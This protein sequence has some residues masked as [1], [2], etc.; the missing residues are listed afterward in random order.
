MTDVDPRV[1]QAQT[2]FWEIEALRRDGRM[3]EASPR[4][5]A[6]ALLHEQRAIE[7]LEARDA[8]GWVDLF[9]AV[10]AFADAG[11]V[12]R[13]ARLLLHGRELLERFKAGRSAVLS[14]LQATEEWLRAKQN[15]PRRKSA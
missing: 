10:T 11:L 12:D 7:L 1:E 3:N 5:Q 4:L 6:M 8:E 9:A 14:E 2:L 15:P 13:A